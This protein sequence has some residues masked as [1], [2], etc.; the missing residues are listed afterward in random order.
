M[1][2]LPQA[3]QFLWH[4]ASH[5]AKCCPN[6]LLPNPNARI[7]TALFLGIALSISSVKIVAMVVGEM[8]FMRRDIGQIIVASA[9]LEDTIGWVLVAVAFGLAAAGSIDVWSLGRAVLG[10][11]LFLA[12]SLTIG[13]RAV[14][15]LIRLANDNFRSDFAVITTILVIMVVMALITQWIGV[16]LVLGAF[17][18]GIL[19]GKSPILT[20]HIDEQLRGLIVALFMPVFFGLTGLS[21]NLTVLA[22]PR[23]AELALGLIV[24]ASAGKFIGAFIGAKLSGLVRSEALAL[25]SAMNARGSTEVIIASIGL[26]MG[27][28]SRDLFTLIVTMAV[29]T[30]MSMPPMLRWALKRVPMRKDERVR[31]EREEIDARGFVTKLERLLVAVDDSASGKFAAQLAGVIGGS[32]GKPTTLLDLTGDEDATKAS[33]GAKGARAARSDTE[34]EPEGAARHVKAAAERVTSLDAHPDEEK[35]GG[36]DVTTVRKRA[37]GPDEIEAEARK[38][39]GLFIIGLADT[40]D[41]KSGFGKEVSRIAAT[42]DGPLAIVD[43]QDS[44]AERLLRGPGKIVVPVNGT[45]ASR[46]AAEV[47]F[48]LARASNAEVAVLY[49][50]TPRD[51]KNG[52]KNAGK[53]DKSGG[54]RLA[55]PTRRNYRAILKDISALAERYDVDVRRNMVEDAAPVEAILKE[56]KR[57]YDLIVLGA[58]RRPGETLFFGNTAAAILDRSPIPKLFIAS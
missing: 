52:G 1:R 9:I 20:R 12:L 50:A 13:R 8:N 14:F 47:A 25:A 26:S 46:R 21:A 11:V 36:I 18:A 43:A 22:N 53:N 27:V 45:E 2:W 33:K 37:I 7:V 42:F 30:T 32:S 6:S 23:L 39:Y 56:A 58:N 40:R 49:V 29:L 41:P 24:I 17:V 51:G 15:S 34:K 19:V 35:R 10:T 55:R 48:A 4:A 44:N 31:L 5:S 3:S 16:N 28:L 38:G 57:D 54:N